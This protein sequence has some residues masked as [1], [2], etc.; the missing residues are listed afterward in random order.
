[1]PTRESV[2]VGAP[3]W[4][5]LASSDPE[6]AKS[7]YGEVFGWTATDGGE[8]YGG[9][10][11]FTLGGSPVAGMMP[12]EPG[13]GYP[14]GWSTYL[15]VVDATATATRAAAAGGQVTSEPMPVADQGVMAFFTD[16][17]GASI[18]AWQ[19]GQHKGYLV[20]DEHGAPW[21]HEL[22]TTAY[23]ASVRFY[24]DVFGWETRVFSDTD[25]YRCTLQVAGG[26]DVAGIE[27]MS[28]DTP[29]GTPSSWEVYFAVDDLDATLAQVVEL[30][31]SVVLPAEETTFGRLAQVT[32]PT[33][34]SF[35][36]RAP[37]AAA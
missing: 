2:A 31:G 8:E 23:D 16:P 26:A 6:Q 13:S 27:E 10:V 21:W 37:S 20:V 33:G 11:T 25:E 5:D 18:G 36:V 12:N 14:D 9:Y 34:A 24:E 28:D 19:P 22:R 15:E 32:D 1:M 17:G 30:G 7:F 4:I 3:C 35:R 29:P